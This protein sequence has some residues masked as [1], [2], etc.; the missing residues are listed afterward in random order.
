LC[1]PAVV[2]RRIRRSEMMTPERPENLRSNRNYLSWDL[3]IF[4]PDVE[5]SVSRED[6]RIILLALYADT[7]TSWRVLTDVR[8]K[9]LGLLPAVSIAIFIS[10]FGTDAAAKMHPVMKVAITVL[11]LVVT[12][13]VAL[14]EQRNDQ[15]YNNLIDRARKIEEELGIDTGQFRGRLK[16]FKKWFGLPV[17]HGLPIATIYGAAALAWLTAVAA[18]LLRW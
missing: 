2:V 7:C 9:L 15:F 10:L 12:L 3:P 4:R 1:L 14:Y 18:A 5:P 16:R 6:R 8:F 17:E 13:A 11:G